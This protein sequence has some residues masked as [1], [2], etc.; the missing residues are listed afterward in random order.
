MSEIEK[1][2]KNEYLFHENL[3]I[4]N[5]YGKNLSYNDENI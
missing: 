1:V 3:K 2:M 4:E 5:E